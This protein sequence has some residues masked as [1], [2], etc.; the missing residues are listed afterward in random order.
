MPRKREPVGAWAKHA[1]CAGRDD[2]AFF[3]PD[4][5]EGRGRPVSETWAKQ[6]LL[7]CAGC[8]VRAE[9]L[10]HALDNHEWAGIWGGTTERQRRE[11]R[12]GRAG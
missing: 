7:L 3:P 8:D 11:M 6:A 10:R 9:C 1:A 5:F 12:M 2:V 4:E